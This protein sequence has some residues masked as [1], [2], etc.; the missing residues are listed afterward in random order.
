MIEQTCA[1]STLDPPGWLQEITSH[2]LYVDLWLRASAF[3]AGRR[4]H[5]GLP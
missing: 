5:P 2:I 1:M 4:G 3:C